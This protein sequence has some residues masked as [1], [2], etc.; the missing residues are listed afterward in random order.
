MVRMVGDKAVGCPMTAEKMAKESH[1]KVVFVV[2][3]QRF[4][5]EPEAYKA[6]ADVSEQFVKRYTSIACVKDGKVMYC[7][8]EECAKSCGDKAKLTSADGRSSCSSGKTAMVKAEGKTCPVTGQKVAAEGAKSCE[9]SAKDAKLVKADEGK[10][11]PLTGKRIAST[12]SKTCDKSGKTAT[13]VSS[14]GQGK[15]CDPSQ[16]KG[17]TFRVAGR[18]F[19]TYDEAAKAREAVLASIAKVKMTYVVDGKKVD[20]ASQVCPRA[21]QAGKVKFVIGSDETCCEYDAR[22]RL[23]KAQFEAAKQNGAKTVATNM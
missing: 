7:S 4:E 9:K 8:E 13:L 1:G 21:K 17:A 2:A 18:D 5:N 6:L 19:K 3:E 14:E 11:C 23:A 22:I 15:G 20:C 16:C 12:E 10:T